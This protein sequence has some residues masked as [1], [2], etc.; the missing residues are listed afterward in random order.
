MEKR[1]FGNTILE[2][3]GNS[4]VCA[5]HQKPKFEIAKL[6]IELRR[7]LGDRIQEEE[8]PYLTS[9]ILSFF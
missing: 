1:V 9:F 7:N 8:I 3:N 2:L 4:L 6:A 5:F